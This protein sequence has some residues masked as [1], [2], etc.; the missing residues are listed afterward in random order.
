MSFRRKDPYGGRNVRAEFSYN[1]FGGGVCLGNRYGCPEGFFPYM[2][3]F[4]VDKGG[5]LT[6]REGKKRIFSA[7]YGVCR[8]VLEY[9]GKYIMQLGAQFYVWDGVETNAPVYLAESGARTAVMFLSGGKA[10][11]MDGTHY[12]CY[13]GTTVSQVSPYIPVIMIDRD[14]D[15]STG[16]VYE[17]HNLIGRGFTV[18]FN[19][20]GDGIYKLPHAELA[21]DDIS[22]TLDGNDISSSCTV[23]RQTGEVTVSGYSS[24]DAGINNLRVTAYLTENACAADRKKI[25]DCTFCEDYGGT[26][27]KGTRM[28]FSGNPDHP[29]HIFRSGLLDVSYF[30]DTDY[31]LVGSES[32]RITAMHKQYGE[33]VVFCENSIHAVSYQMSQGV[34]VFTSRTLNAKIGCDMPK[35]IQ[36][37]NNNLVFGSSRRGIF[38]ISSSS[39]ENENNILPISYNVNKTSDGLLEKNEVSLF[40]ACSADFDGKYW[41]FAGTDCYIWDY[42]RRSYRNLSDTKRA[43]TELIWYLFKNFYGKCPFECGGKLY[44]FPVDNKLVSYGGA[45]TDTDVPITSKLVT[46]PSGLGTPKLSKKL[47]EAFISYAGLSSGNATL[48]V[49]C[50]GKDDGAESDGDYRLPFSSFGWHTFSWDGFSF[51]TEHSPKY[52][53]VFF[54]SPKAHEFSFVISSNG[55]RFSVSRLDIDYI[56]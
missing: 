4:I 55:G 51:E 53:R 20:S 28:F 5:R 17:S 24:S 22:V 40:A 11:L 2:E 56:V 9:E 16:T 37:V 3:N 12:Y 21:D 10:Y 34:P 35:S 45:D 18:W 15:G 23:N 41:L 47:K 54:A 25:F 30:P 36:L 43:Q 33:L 38:I 7:S 48:S 52:K 42:T 32:G 14:A 50:D 13:D 8:G 19:F 44:F 26:N 31:E 6:V 49:Y 46:A 27:G 1:N 29:T 39:S